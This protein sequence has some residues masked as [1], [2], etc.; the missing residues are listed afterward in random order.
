MGGRPSASASATTCG[1]SDAEPRL[2]DVTTWTCLVKSATVRASPK[3]AE[4]NVGQHV[5]RAGHVVA[6]AAPATT[7]REDR[8]GVAHQRQQRLGVGDH[9][10]EVLGGDGVGDRDGLPG[11]STSTA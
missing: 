1:P 10:L 11:P 2:V 9:Q 4:P 6:D 3:R 8:A 5:A 7:A